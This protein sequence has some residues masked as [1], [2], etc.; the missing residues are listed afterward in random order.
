MTAGSKFKIYGGEG[1]E[2]V[3]R[4]EFMRWTNVDFPAPAIPMVIIT[5]GFFFGALVVCSMVLLERSEG[6]RK[7]RNNVTLDVLML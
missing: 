4:Y 3:C 7:Y 5:I 1:G 6:R 2:R